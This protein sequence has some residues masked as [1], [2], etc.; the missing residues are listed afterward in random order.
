M[1]RGRWN[2]RLPVL[3]TGGDLLL[4]NA[5]FEL[6]NFGTVVA[7][8]SQNDDFKNG[9]VG[10]HVNLV[11]ELGDERTQRFEESD[12]NGFEV[13]RGLVGKALIMLVGG[14]GD[15]LEIAIEA[16][17]LRIGRNLPLG[18][19]EDDAHVAGV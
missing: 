5:V 10:L 19:A 18:R 9:V 12:A 17:G 14:A 16:D 7:R 11:M 3:A 6:P 13:G 15:T 8:K 2:A 4:I 1:K